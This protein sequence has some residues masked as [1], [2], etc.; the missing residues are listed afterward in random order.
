MRVIG[1][2]LELRRRH[3]GLNRKMRT[4]LERRIEAWRAL[5]G[6]ECVSARR[7]AHS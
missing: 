3:P 4:T 1:V 2:F 5:H 7:L 6:S